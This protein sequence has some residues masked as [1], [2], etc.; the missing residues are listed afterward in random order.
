MDSPLDALIR[1]ESDWLQAIPKPSSARVKKALSL[2]TLSTDQLNYLNIGLML[3]TLV[4]ALVRPFELFLVAYAVLGPLHYLTEI[5]W[6]HDRKYYTRGKKDWVPLVVCAGII[7]LLDMQI[8]PNLPSW[9]RV[10]VTYLAFGGALVFALFSKARPRII[11]LL[12]LLATTPLVVRIDFFHSLF[13]VLL[14][15]IVHV[16]IFTGL[17]ILVGAL[18]GR[19]T[20]GIGSLVVFCLCTASFFILGPANSA[21]EIAEYVQKTYLAFAQLNFSLMTPFRLHDVSVPANLAE[22]IRYINEVL[23]RTPAALAIM[24]LISFAYTYHYLNWF[25]KT[26]I[27]QWHN[28]P[29][30]RFAGVIVIWAASVAAYAFDYRLGLRWLFFLSLTHVFLEFPLNHLTLINIG[31]ELKAIFSVRRTLEAN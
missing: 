6:L 1:P 4:G 10:T 24:G 28:I 5:S 19:S 9:V 14:P 31:K 13:S 7:T 22:Y 29:R 8:V 25:S 3:V 12:G 20:S 27:I 16:F 11:S 17:F 2:S 21:G 18:R 26:S 30:V 23:Y 15:T